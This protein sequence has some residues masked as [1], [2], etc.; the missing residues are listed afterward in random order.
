[1]LGCIP[2]S[3]GINLLVPQFSLNLPSSLQGEGYGSFEEYH[4][5]EGPEGEDSEGLETEDA[6]GDAAPPAKRARVDGSGSGSAGAAQAALQP[7]VMGELE[8]RMGRPGGGD[9]GEPGT[10]AAKAEPPARSGVAASGGGGFRDP[11][12]YKSASLAA[13]GSAAAM[14]KQQHPQQPQPR[15]PGSRGKTGREQ[16]Q[17]A[18]LVGCELMV[19]G[20]CL[21]HGVTG[22]LLG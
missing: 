17:P 10:S 11:S 12:A 9:G 15:A 16:I 8:T 6:G 5:E 4:G 14:V 20:E 21:G 22:G 13:A 7:A 2:V 18:A 1:M 19:P 3:A